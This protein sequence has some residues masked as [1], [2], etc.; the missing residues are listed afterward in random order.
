MHQ[1]LEIKKNKN[2]RNWIIYKYFREYFP[3]KVIKTCE[4]DPTKPY[5][6]A[7]HPHGIIGM[8][9]WANFISDFPGTFSDLFPNIN[10]RYVTL[11][12]N[13]FTP[14]FR[15]ILLR[16]GFIDADKETIMGQLKKNTSVLIL[17]GGAEEA[18][19]ARPGSN[20]L[21]LQKRKGFIKIA[22]QSGKN[23]YYLLKFRYK[24]GSCI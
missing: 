7:T 16:Q 23:I 8:T 3:A 19:L 5:I 6:F 10:I 9:V 17:V 2:Y 1:R 15:E 13:F 20:K 21:I 22:L 18:L 11:K 24:C 12:S 14:F 4:L